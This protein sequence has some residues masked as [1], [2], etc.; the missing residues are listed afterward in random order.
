MLKFRRSMCVLLF[1]TLSFLGSGVRAD[2]TGSILGVVR[3]PTSAVIAGVQITV[4]NTETNQTQSTQSDG[5]GQYRI[6]ALSVGSYRLEASAQGFQKFV[7][8]GIDL[9]VNEQK[10]VD[11]TL[12]VGSIE[13]AV[14]VNATAV[15]V[16]T[17]NTQLGEV[18]DTKKVLSLPLNGR[19]YIDLLGLQAG[20]VPTTVGS[21]QQDRPVSGDLSAGNISVN[22]QRETAN[23]FLVNGG[24][25][26]EGRNL[27][28]AVIPN[29]DAV[30][31]FRLLTNSFDAEYG[32]FSGA[33]MNAVT[34]SGSNG[35]HGDVFEFLRNDKLDARNFF[36]PSRGVFRRNQ[37]GY[38]VG[39]PL[40]KNKI[41]WFTD[42]QGTREARG[43]SSGLLTVPSAVERG[44]DFSGEG[45][46]TGS[47]QG[48]YWAQV[49]SNRL[50]YTVSNLEPYG[51]CNDPANC[52]FPGDKIPQKAFAP[53]TLPTMKYI[54]LPNFG[55]NL[56]ST[57]G[58]NQTVRDDKAGQ[59]VDIN[60]QKT[61][62]W[63]VYYY[64]DDSTLRNPFGGANLPGFPTVT[65]QRAQQAVLSNTKV[66]GPGTVN[67]A[68]VSFLRSSVVTDKPTAGF[69]KLSDLGFVENKGLG[70][71]PSGPPGFEGLPPLSF[72][73]LGVSVGT[74][75]LTTTQPDNTWSFSEALSKIVGPHTLKM[76][77][78]FRYF[79]INE[80]NVCG[81]N[82]SFEF[83]GSET[84]SDFADYLIGAPVGYTQCSMQ[85]LDSR[86]RYGGAFFQDSFRVKPNIT[87]NYGLRWEVSMPWYDTQNKIETLVLGEQSTQFPTAPKGW[88]VP[89][90]PGI[91]TTLAPTR[92]NN[93]A[94][95]LGLAYSPGF[96]EGAL[97][98]IF[99]G[100]GKTSIR[101]SFGIY[102]TSIEDLN[103]FY[104]VG[105]APYGLYWP[106]IVPPLFELPFQDR[107]DGRSQTQ[108][109]PF[110]F[111][112]PGSPANKTLNYSVFLPI[113]GSPGYDI[114]NK[115]PYAEHYNFSIQ[116]TLTP[117]TVLTLAY[118]GTQGH[119]LIAQ[120]ES[121]PGNPQLCLSL[122]GSGV[123]P[124]TQE[125]G[126]SGE[127]G[128]YTRPDGS[129][130]NGT[131]G[132]FGP[133]FGSNSFTSNI[134]N[135]NYNALQVTVERKAA[136]ITFL[137]AYTFS[138]AMDDSSAYGESVNFT[139]YRLSRALSQYDLTHNFVFSYNWSL[140]FDKAAALPKR[141]TQ[142]WSLIGITRFATGFPVG[143][144]QSGDLSLLGASGVNEP[145]F[146]GG[147]VIQDPRNAGGDGRP[148]G[149][150]NRSAFTSGPL[151]GI[152]NSNRRFFHGPGLNNFDM[153]LHK[154]TKVREGMA[155]EFRA[156]FFNAF[157]H[158]QFNNPNGNFA[159]GRFGHVRSAKAP[160][161]GQLALKFVW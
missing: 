21:M 87:L 145:N 114:H 46:L 121:N 47:V 122:M 50:G 154:T 129:V 133:N 159:S 131:R 91:P 24:D 86:T 55:S 100:P 41:F 60:N 95:R 54:P 15:Q 111:P 106:S 63:Y 67:E 115:L 4:T 89:G 51:G 105:D 158:A 104:E 39:G 126:P 79:Q 13:Q 139:N 99:G 135:S 80:R 134:A 16:E 93:F 33:I 62:N 152:G 20:V 128:V 70:I 76:G 149:Y 124:G 92:Y 34:K 109:F 85:F 19:S 75:T 78:E 12:Q 150:F 157:N 147:L 56:F 27:G 8:T 142:G 29:L 48:P 161:I 103:L 156:E 14:E 90:D 31:E 49:L 113:Q 18:I 38:A 32:K 130:V 10:R 96:S 72:D 65:P 53:P 98:K 132:P 52:V 123:M 118:V 9:T 17:T 42:Y 26:T 125:C 107:G 37:F 140:P 148:N 116:R 77:G 83:S 143:I 112:I 11:I 110:V 155:V 5:T 43:I 25:V 28:A 64:F 23:A 40:W 160:R 137:G 82:G 22:G 136:D 146:V 61:G 57:A 120:R 102:Y 7:T 68:R 88:V 141:L 151:G 69:G 30:A 35:I 73:L 59:R 2:V 6:L 58:Q 45:V 81:P 108:R 138:K 153:A 71:F 119:K 144:S 36:D 94:P 127:L 3:D 74:N 84:G 97:G 44:G 117:A 101:A 1:G 66:F